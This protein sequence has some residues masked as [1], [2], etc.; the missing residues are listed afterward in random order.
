MFWLTIKKNNFQIGTLI[1]RPAIIFCNYFEV[2]LTL[3]LLKVDLS[4]NEISVDYE[5]KEFHLMLNCW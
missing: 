5:F 2:V 1:W 3:V 4:F